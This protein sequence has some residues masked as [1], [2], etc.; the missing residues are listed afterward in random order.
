M[1]RISSLTVFAVAGCLAISIS[2]S[3][4]GATVEG[5]ELG[6]YIL[7]VQTSAGTVIV[8]P[9]PIGPEFGGAYRFYAEVDGIDLDVIPAPTVS[10]PISL[11]EPWHNGG[12]MGWNAGINQWRY[13]S[14]DFDEWATE[15]AAELD[16]LFANGI[17]T[18]SNVLG[19]SASVNLT[20]DAYPNMPV[21]TLTGGAWIGGNYQIDPSQPLTVTTDAFTAYGSNPGDLMELEL[22]GDG[23]E[24]EEEQFS[25]E[26]AA[27]DFLTITVPANTLTAGEMYGLRAERL[28]FVDL[29]AVTS[30]PDAFV[31]AG[32]GRETFI[33]VQAIPEPTSLTLLGLAGLALLRRRR[34]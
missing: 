5:M 6:K 31:L 4:Y 14:P 29:H 28:S 1:R 9:T 22:F 13:G 21:M 23:V 30:L 12:V 20:G 33:T 18:F 16:G 15:T 19:A 27:P 2:G 25:L 26:M 11:A 8:N 32:Y 24:V 10:G 17:Y 34:K 3:A 7:H